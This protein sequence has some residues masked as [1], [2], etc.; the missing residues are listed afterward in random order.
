MDHMG[1][2]VKKSSNKLSV[3]IRLDFVMFGLVIENL[4]PFQS[5]L[6]LVFLCKFE[7]FTF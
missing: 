2:I 5:L 1:H 4:L 6:T 7:V 3:K